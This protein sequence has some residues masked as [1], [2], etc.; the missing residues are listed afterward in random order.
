MNNR[1][2][3]NKNKRTTSLM[4]GDLSHE[5]LE[6]E[7]GRLWLKE[8]FFDASQKLAHLGYCEWDY[9]KGRI[10]SCTP[11]YAEIFGMSIEEV[12][13]SQ[14]TWEKVLLQIHP[15]DRD[16]YAQ[17]YREHMGKGSHEVEYRVFRNDGAIR[18]LKEVAIL[19]QD[20]DR[21]RKESIGL[22]Q[23]V[24]E[25]ATMRKTIEQNAEK[26]KL[27][28]R[29]AKLGY[30]HFDEVAN[31]YI[32]I[33][34]E[35]AAIVG[36]TVPEFLQRFRTL[37]EDM[38]MV[39]PDDSDAL[40]EAYETLEGRIDCS[41]R[42]R[43]RNGHWIHVR[44]IST[45]ITDENGNCI[46]S[47]GTLQDITELTEA[48]LRAEQANRAKNQFLSRMSHELR[49]P[50]NAILGYS[51]LIQSDTRLDEQQQSRLGAIFDAGQHLLSLINEVLDLSRL[52]E[53]DIEISIAPV[54]LDGIIEECVNLVAAMAAK[55][56]I[57]IDCDLDS[58][59]GVT[60]EADAVRLK[61]VFLNLISN[62]VK[63]NRENGNVR[64]FCVSEGL[65]RV[66]ISVADDGAGI[67]PDRIG[68]LF[69]P[70][71]RLGAESSE[72]EGTGIGLLIS[73]QLVELMQGDLLVDSSPDE[74]S[75]FSVC[76]RASQVRAVDTAS[77]HAEPGS[78]QYSPD[79]SL[80][81]APR[82]LVAEDNDVNREL[83]AAQLEY[84]GYCADFA[85]TG[86][87]ALAL[88][89]AGDYPLL[90]T[91]IRMPGMD[92]NELISRIRSLE[93]AGSRKPI[94]AA[95]AS[96][97]AADVQ[98]CLDAG[99]DEVIAKPL[100]L[101]VLQQA[102]DKW[103]PQTNAG[104]A[105]AS[106]ANSPAAQEA[107]AEA[108]DVSMLRQSV[109]DRVDLQRRLLKTYIEAMPKSLFDIRQAFAWRNLEQLEGF[110]HKLKSSSINLGAM[111]V[112]QICSRLETACR[113][114]RDAE[115]ADCLMQLQQATEAVETFVTSFCKEP[116]EAA[117][118]LY[119]SPK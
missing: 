7:V 69:E 94:I 1:K 35:Y 4:T 66:R 57:T 28:A 90:L 85:S 6:A 113:E 32:D 119:D 10:I 89:R 53:G 31:E 16:H 26:L 74:G 98:Q 47:I 71:N 17:S 67:S 27:A 30:W 83:I 14:S 59:R 3:L 51:Q 77:P 62:A 29:T 99:A 37:D 44:E 40:H 55:Q 110:A 107:Q 108:I 117:K 100:V 92:G 70:F 84:L 114:H 12:I 91:D 21:G 19:R 56:G 73:R 80:L 103:M 52:E 86:A 105:S 36:Y 97:M 75:I 76:L 111:R 34:E 41:Y 49:T 22:V 96:A 5:E 8:A 18:H 88:W 101:D 60:V 118:A 64:V 46:E 43:H 65:E 38:T 82:I 13:E 106:H 48:Q 79:Q 45:D 50:L 78:T 58:L 33:S 109:G 24:T 112:A 39:H 42:I 68:E 116:A 95:T 9:D 72:I 87:E 63:Y 20:G 115:I 61:Q 104:A 15:E 11:S 23:D 25:H 102:L 2:Q 54:S 81:A 93:P